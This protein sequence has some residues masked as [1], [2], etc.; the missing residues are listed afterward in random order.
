MISPI[1]N[2]NF[3]TNHSPSFKSC[4]KSFSFS[5]Y[6]NQ[7]YD[8]FTRILQSDCGNETVAYKKINTD[9][10]STV[11]LKISQLNKN[12]II[13]SRTEFIGNTV[14]S[15][16][17][18]SNKT[19]IIE[20]EFDEKNGVYLLL[21]QFEIYEDKKGAPFKIIHSKR[22]DKY[23]DFIEITEYELKNYDENLDVIQAIK[24]GSITGG[25][26]LSSVSCVQNSCIALD[27]FC[28]NDTTVKRFY[29]KEFDKNGEIKKIIYSYK[30]D[31]FFGNNILNI[32]RTFEKN[33]DGTTTTTVQDRKYIT[34]F[35]DEK[36]IIT[37]TNQNGSQIEIDVAK[38]YSK[39]NVS[40]LY[41]FFKTL[42][43]DLLIQ[44]NNCDLREIHIFNSPLDSAVAPCANGFGFKMI[45]GELSEEIFAHEIGHVVDYSNFEK[46]LENDDIKNIYNAEWEIFKENNPDVIEKE[47]KYFSHLSPA[48]SLY[49]P[50][51]T[52]FND[53]GLREVV[54]EVNMLTKCYDLSSLT[55]NRAKILVRYF[56]N[57][58]AMIAKELETSTMI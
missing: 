7:G 4:A 13:F 41:K 58:I 47:I 9:D 40:K 25:K 31:D 26:K 1:K 51:R 5:K 15:R 52:H 56:P 36:R 54:A 43:A 3:A 55:S 18:N 21:H 22:N 12:D 38:S 16:I 29:S 10:N 23:S 2:Y 57:T 19:I 17:K 20:K 53:G 37:I 39:I 24:D 45:L 35:D 11:E 46:L 34:S 30:I 32:D 48:R 42:P 8:V 49:V 50:N 14:I 6:Q 27:E 33:S 28:E 44:L